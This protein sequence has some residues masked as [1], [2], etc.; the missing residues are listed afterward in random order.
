MARSGIKGYNIL[1]RGNM[2]T[3]VND[4]DESKDK[5]VTIVFKILD[6]TSYNKLILS[7][8]NMVCFLIFETITYGRYSQGILI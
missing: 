7:Q 3:M 1:L 8:E 2:D 4:T 6:K 5:G